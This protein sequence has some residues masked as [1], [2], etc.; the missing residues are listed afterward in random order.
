MKQATTKPRPVPTNKLIQERN[1]QRAPVA[2]KTDRE[3]LDWY[4]RE[5][6]LFDFGM[7]I[8]YH[9]YPR[10]PRD[11]AEDVVIDTLTRFT[12]NWP[13]HQSKDH[14]SRTLMF[15]VKVLGW[16][17]VDHHRNRMRS[18]D[19]IPESN[20]V[21]GAPQK[22]WDS[23]H[24]SPLESAENVIA[25][26]D[27]YRRMKQFLDEPSEMQRPLPGKRME[28]QMSDILDLLWEGRSKNSEIG[29]ALG[30][31]RVAAHRRKGSTIRR[32]RDLGKN[33]DNAGELLD[34]LAAF[35]V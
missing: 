8:M 4:V 35:S 28:Y 6:D 21:E 14:V 20:L 33:V 3:I 9:R 17:A 32:L 27:F 1:D 10:C 5:F 26:D 15:F 31:E 19:A 23:A 11:A 18:I 29:K 16:C 12:I 13:K 7:K 34:V 25:R 24:H 22:A 30:V 2:G